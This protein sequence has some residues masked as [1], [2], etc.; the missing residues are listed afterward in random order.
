MRR[1]RRPLLALIALILALLVGYVVQALT[2]SDS[3]GPPSPRP[4]VVHSMIATFGAA[5]FR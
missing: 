3:G 2:E 1:V 4:S 5:S